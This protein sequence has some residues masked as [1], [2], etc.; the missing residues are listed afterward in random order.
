MTETDTKNRPIANQTM[1][2]Y[3][4]TLLMLHCAVIS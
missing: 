1:G 4:C 2:S 3:S